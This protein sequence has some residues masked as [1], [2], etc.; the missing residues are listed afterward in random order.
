MVIERNLLNEH[1]KAILDRKK[2]A[3]T[4]KSSL[5]DVVDTELKIINENEQE[6]HRL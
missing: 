4:I 5:T 3:L 1:H 2:D 6:Y